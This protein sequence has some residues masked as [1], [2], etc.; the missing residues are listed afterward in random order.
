M[1]FLFIKR[2]IDTFTPAFEGDQ[3]AVFEKYHGSFI[4]KEPWIFKNIAKLTV[5]N[6]D[7][8]ADIPEEVLLCLVRG[9]ISEF[10]K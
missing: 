6:N 5:Q 3:G 8:F 10:E 7:K 4:S 9:R 2:K 1:D